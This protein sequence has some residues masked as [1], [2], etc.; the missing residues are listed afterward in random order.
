MNYK[1][2]QLVINDIPSRSPVCD[3]PMV[4]YYTEIQ[5]HT[6]WD[7]SNWAMSLL[8]TI[9]RR[10]N[11]VLELSYWKYTGPYQSAIVKVVGFKTY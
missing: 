6:S 11:T 10:S 4:T 5:S 8:G 7:F 3:V 9:V 1:K 2:I